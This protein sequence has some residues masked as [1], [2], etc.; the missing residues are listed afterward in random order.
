MARHRVKSPARD[1]RW[2]SRT[3]QRSKKINIDPVIYRGGIRL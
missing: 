1:K 3:A 2:F